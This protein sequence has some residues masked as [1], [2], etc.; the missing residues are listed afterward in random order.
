MDTKG[1]DRQ[2]LI[3]NKTQRFSYLIDQAK[4]L[5]LT[6]PGTKFTQP[7]PTGNNNRHSKPND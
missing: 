3:A 4:K 6:N 2:P 5:Y 7:S 1:W